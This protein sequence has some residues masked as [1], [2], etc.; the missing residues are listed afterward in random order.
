M[1]RLGNGNLSFSQILDFQMATFLGLQ[2][3]TNMGRL[4]SSLKI[5]NYHLAHMS[6][7]HQLLP[8]VIYGVT[9][10]EERNFATNNPQLLEFN[11]I[12]P[13]GD[14][15]YT[16]KNIRYFSNAKNDYVYPNINDEYLNPILKHI[17]ELFGSQILLLEGDP[18][19][20]QEH[21]MHQLTDVEVYDFN[22]VTE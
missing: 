2:I 8:Q 18:L 16:L 17:A 11:L 7:I 22:A 14:Q 13:Y 15:Y 20:G 12:G 19:Q 3:P 10:C 1:L 9:S 21:Y 6:Q 4:P 5:G